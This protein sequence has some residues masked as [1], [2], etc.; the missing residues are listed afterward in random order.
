MQQL[1]RKR[2][3]SFFYI[4]FHPCPQKKLRLKRE[5]EGPGREIL[6]RPCQVLPWYYQRI[7]LATICF[8]Y[9]VPL[10]L[11]RP[12]E[13]PQTPFY[14]T[15]IHYLPPCKRIKK[16]FGARCTLSQKEGKARAKLLWGFYFMLSVVEADK[17]LHPPSLNC[18][19]SCYTLWTSVTSQ[20]SLHPGLGFPGSTRLTESRTWIHF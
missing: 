16:L 18:L 2:P 9:T 19:I 17:E 11:Y 5:R 13:P 3:P 15:L 7:N 10:C 6:R 1:K 14:Q 12:H 8:I 4:P 20:A